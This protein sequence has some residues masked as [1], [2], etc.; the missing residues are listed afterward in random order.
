MAMDSTADV[1]GV[2]AA[3]KAENDKLEKEKLA[4]MKDRMKQKSS[5]GKPNSHRVSCEST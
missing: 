3:I 5:H 2:L 4:E 1:S